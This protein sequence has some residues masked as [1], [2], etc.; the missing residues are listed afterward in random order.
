MN[1]CVI[2]GT[3][4]RG[5][6]SLYA[7]QVT[8]GPN[9]PYAIG[10]FSPVSGTPQLLDSRVAGTTSPPNGRTWGANWEGEILL[11]FTTNV[12]TTSCMIPPASVS[13]DFP[14]YAVKCSPKFVR[15]M[16]NQIVHFSPGAIPIFLDGSLGPNV[17]AAIKQSILDWNLVQP[18]VPLDW[19][20]TDC[21]GQAGC[22]RVVVGVVSGDCAKS[23][24]LSSGGLITS[25]TMT[26]PQTAEN[27]NPNFLRRTANH[28]LGHHLGLGENNTSCSSSRSIMAPTT[29]NAPNGFPITPPPTDSLPVNKTTYGGGSAVSCPS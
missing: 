2:T 7:T 9:P 16:A 15:N 8:G 3:E 6:A 4:L 11:R 5:V 19:T 12:H 22:V 14:V 28:E 25:S 26:F 13:V 1:A 17:K 29:C 20:T 21:A 10:P 18:N 23:Q 24:I 27:W